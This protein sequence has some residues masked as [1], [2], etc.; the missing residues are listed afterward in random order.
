[1][2]E[3]TIGLGLPSELKSELYSF[4]KFYSTAELPPLSPGS[5]YLLAGTDITRQLQNISNDAL[6]LSQTRRFKYGVLELEGNHAIFDCIVYD[7]L[8]NYSPK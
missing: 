3:V 5:N 1:M 2:C 6:L 7:E 4:I 8:V